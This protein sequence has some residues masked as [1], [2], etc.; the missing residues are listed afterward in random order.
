MNQI[1]Y[2]L[3]WLYTVQPSPSLGSA[4]PRTGYDSAGITKHVTKAEKNSLLNRFK[5]FYPENDNAIYS[6]T[7]C[8]DIPDNNHP[9][10]VNLGEEP[11]H[12]FIILSKTDT[13][14]GGVSIYQSFGFYPHRPVSCLIFKKV[15]GVIIDNQR[16]EYNASVY[17]I[18]SAQ[19][20][21]LVQQKSAKLA[22]KKY[23]LNKYNCYDYAI[24][25]FN[26]IPGIEKMP[27]SR[28]KFPFIFGKG[29]S[30]CCLYRD[31]QRLRQGGS[32]WA[33]FIQFG[34]FKSPPSCSP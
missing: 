12:V 29:G 19:E 11:G 4:S 26:S 2:T 25:V 20:F 3:L 23:S 15:R 21:Q 9:D 33:Q 17:K 5:C 6:I 8:A 18:L 22:K 16:R 10:H 34:M 13:S 27:V 30:P 31:L 24:E 32:S 14:T 1:I 28:I 7:L